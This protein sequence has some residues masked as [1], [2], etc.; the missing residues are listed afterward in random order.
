MSNVASRPDKTEDGLTIIYDPADVPEFRSDA[1]EVAY[2]ETHT[3]SEELMDEAAQTPRDPRMP[4]PR[5]EPKR[6]KSPTIS[7]RLSGDTIERFKRLAEKRDTGYQTLMKQFML[8]RLYEEEKRE[9]V[10]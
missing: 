9:G 7:L 5:S 8:E 6:Q 4:T 3:W 2:W 1:E 10:I